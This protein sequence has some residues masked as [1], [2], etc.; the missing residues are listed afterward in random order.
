MKVA[1]IGV[2]LIG[3]SLVAAWRRAGL[4]AHVAGFDPDLEA[5]A[6]GISRRVIDAAADSIAAAATDADLVLVATP[7]G[8][9]RGVFSHLA[10]ALSPTALVTDVG[11]TKADVLAAAAETLGPALGRFVPAHPIAG[12]DLS[13]VSAASA[14]LFDGKR[15]V[16]TPTEQTDP[17]ALQR[18]E[19][20]L[21]KAGGRVIRMSAAQHDR[22]FA[23]VSHL[24]H[25]AAFAL[26]DAIARGDD[27]EKVLS[28]GGTGLRDTT[29]VAASSPVMWR[30][31]CLANRVALGDELRAYRDQLDKLQRAIDAADAEFIERT[32]ERAA[33]LRRRMPASLDNE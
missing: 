24:P 21:E 19:A 33:R 6:Q 23:A 16:T 8:A 28:F 10:R 2:G 1:L 22:V 20:L 5:I 11:S 14:A 18:I 29:R 4:V 13:G 31:I 30:D 15:I 32:F 12:S 26:V 17:E 9:M 3:G 27:G 25:L 7:V